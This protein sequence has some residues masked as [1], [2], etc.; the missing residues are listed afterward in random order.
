MQE[1]VCVEKIEVCPGFVVTRIAVM[2]CP[3]FSRLHFAKSQGKERCGPQATS[4]FSCGRCQRRKIFPIYLLIP[5][6]GPVI[7]NIVQVDHQEF[8]VVHREFHKSYNWTY[9]WIHELM[10]STVST[11]SWAAS[12]ANWSIRF[13][14]KTVVHGSIKG[15]EVWTTGLDWLPH[16]DEKLSLSVKSK[17][18]I[19]YWNISDIIIKG[20]SGPENNDGWG[21]LQF[22]K[23]YTTPELLLHH[24]L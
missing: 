20:Q 23:N 24:Q 6:P 16:V 11:C 8:L 1:F 3:T 10:C 9:P 22:S 21:I 2:S 4:W 15:C 13:F 14:L 19:H 12:I 5:M 7:L 18:L 17:H